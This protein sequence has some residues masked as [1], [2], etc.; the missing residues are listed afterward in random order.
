MNGGRSRFFL[1]S[2]LTPDEIRLTV[3]TARE[4]IKKI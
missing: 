3:Q 2:E 4:E 1:N